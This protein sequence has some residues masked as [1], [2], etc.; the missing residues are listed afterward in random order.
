MVS[1]EL[2]IKAVRGDIPWQ[3]C[4]N[5]NC[6]EEVFIAPKDIVQMLYKFLKKSITATELQEWAGWVITTESLCVKGWENDSIADH[7]EPMW[8]CIQELS[9]PFLDGD[10]S[11][12][13][14]EE[15]VAIIE[16]YP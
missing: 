1:K 9:T 2:I 13:Q 5:T 16:G 4:S 15:C 8:S 14:V 12:S 10:I 7:Y 3:D 11:S 6:E